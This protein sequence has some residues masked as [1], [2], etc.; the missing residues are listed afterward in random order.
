MGKILSKLFRGSDAP[1]DGS[2]FVRE[3]LA[4]GGVAAAVL[5]V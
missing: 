1:Q 4:G 3:D 5:Q 2:V